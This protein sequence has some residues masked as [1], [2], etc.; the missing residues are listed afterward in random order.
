MNV[1]N[2]YYKQLTD[3]LVF[4]VNMEEEFHKIA[5]DNYRVAEGEAFPFSHCV[6][7]LQQLPEFNTMVDGGAAE[8][9]DGDNKPAT[10]VNK[11]GAPM[12]ASL[13]RPPGS[14]RAKKKLLLRDLSSSGS[15]STSTTMEMMAESQSVMAASQRSL[16]FSVAQQKRIQQLKEQMSAIQIEFTMHQG[17]GDLDEQAC[18]H[19]HHANGFHRRGSYF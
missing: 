18:C 1:Y 10:S 14:K 17:V 2:K 16:A 3:T 11:I 8:V 5:T 12:G 9:S 13:K 7:V 6:D 4:G 15:S 19:H